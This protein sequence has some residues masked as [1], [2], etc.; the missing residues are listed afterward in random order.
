MQRLPGRPILSGWLSSR[1]G[2]RIDP[3]SGKKAWHEGIDFAGREGGHI[4]AV[5]SGVCQL[6]RRACGLRLK[7]WRSRTAMV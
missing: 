3:F 2:S 7:W 1:Y 4:V 6:E 5:A